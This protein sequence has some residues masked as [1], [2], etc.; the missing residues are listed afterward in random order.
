[1]LLSETRS[2]SLFS[3]PTTTLTKLAL[4]A[5]LQMF[6]LLQTIFSSSIT[7]QSSLLADIASIPIPL[8]W[9]PQAKRQRN[10]GSC[11]TSPRNSIFDLDRTIRDSESGTSHRPSTC[12]T[13]RSGSITNLNEKNPVYESEDGITRTTSTRFP[14]PALLEVLSLT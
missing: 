13:S 10:A 9:T 5:T 8:P 6:S 2:R 1:L 12:P 7:Y 11:P 4:S 3:L 14:Y